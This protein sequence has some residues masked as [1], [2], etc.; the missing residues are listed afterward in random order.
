[1]VPDK[2]EKIM[3]TVFRSMC[4]IAVGLTLSAGAM[5]AMSKDEFKAAKARIASEYKAAKTACNSQS[6]NAKDICMADAK[7]KQNV[8]K[9]ELDASYEPSAKADYGVSMAKAKAAYSVATENA[10]TRP[11]AKRGFARMAPSRTKPA[12]STT[13]RQL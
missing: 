5:A 1:M 4:A 10:T 11:A 12:P 6:A 3:N 13:R 2:E 7:G 9:A 8:A